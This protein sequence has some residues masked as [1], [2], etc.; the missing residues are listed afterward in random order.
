MMVKGTSA[1][2]VL[3][4]VHGSK[5]MPEIQNPLELIK[6]F[7]RVARSGNMEQEALGL[8][9]TNRK[10]EIRKRKAECEDEFPWDQVRSSMTFTLALLTEWG[11]TPAMPLKWT[12]PSMEDGDGSSVPYHMDCQVDA[13]VH[14]RLMGRI[15]KEKAWAEVSPP[16]GERGP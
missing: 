8:A 2:L 4:W 14:L 15:L 5:G 9:W 10:E 16:R 11:I 6:A 7:L 12:G 1:T 3:A 13:V